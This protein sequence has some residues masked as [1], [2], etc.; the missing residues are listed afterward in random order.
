MPFVREHVPRV[1]RLHAQ[2]HVSQKTRVFRLPAIGAP[3]I[4]PEHKQ[5]LPIQLWSCLQ[6]L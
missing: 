3:N 1:G 4:Q 5:V 6:S 2:R